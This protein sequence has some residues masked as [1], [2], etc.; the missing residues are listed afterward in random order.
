MRGRN[1]SADKYL[2]AVLGVILFLFVI[3]LLVLHHKTQNDLRAAHKTEFVE[4]VKRRA[5]GLGFFFTDRRNDL[6]D[7]AVSPSLEAYFL[8]KD[9]GVS[10]QY[11][12]RANLEE[13]AGT[14]RR[15]VNTRR[16]GSRADAVYERMVMVD[17][18][19]TALIDVTSM[20]GNTSGIHELQGANLSRFL[21]KDETDAV[22][23]FDGCPSA[24]VVVVLRPLFHKGRFVGQVLAWLRWESI[25]EHQLSVR[26][27]QA[28]VAIADNEGCAFY[29]A[30]REELRSSLAWRIAGTVDGGAVTTEGASGDRTVAVAVP[31]ATTPFRFV[32]SILEATLLTGNTSV[33]LV[34]GLYGLTFLLLVSGAVI[35]RNGLRRDRLESELRDAQKLEAVGQLAGGIAHEINTPSQYISNNLTFLADAHATLFALVRGCLALI[36]D[37]KD[38]EEFADRMREID[39]LR[40]G[41]DLD[42]LAEE[43]PSAT[44]QSIFGIKQISRIVLAMKEFSHPGVQGKAPTDLNRAIENTITISRNEWKHVAKVETAFDPA[45]PAVICLPGEITQVLLNLLV[46]AAHAVR[47]AGHDAN[48]GRIRIATALEGET[49]VIRVEDNGTG[50]PEAIRGKVF[51]PFFTTKEVG[52]GTGQGLTIARDIVVNKHGGAIRFETRTGKGTTFVVH[53]PVRGVAKGNANAKG[54]APIGGAPTRESI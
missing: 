25:Q 48:D 23:R 5:D 15:L 45:L 12:L 22:V 51:N 27:R 28:A 50:I 35:W 8:N 2:L 10:L 13:V 52:K 9:L 24:P 41:A 30:P 11:G 44:E 17:A 19:G 3:V 53:L 33:W 40:R 16:F 47:A 46:N 37:L 6:D 38:R 1:T 7:L 36:D 4:E 39:N 26:R 29:D 34:G 32:A 54:K 31:V 49:A 14:M 18:A 20:G 43:I 21:A 42:F